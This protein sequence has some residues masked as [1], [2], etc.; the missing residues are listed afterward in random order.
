MDILTFVAEI[1]KALAWPLATIVIVT[2]FRRPLTQLLPLLRRVKYGDLEAEF[3][4]KI[5]EAKSE[6]A[7]VLPEVT[8]K[9][10]APSADETRL[11]QLSEISPRAAV[12]EAF[13]G[14][15]LAAISAARK[16]GMPKAFPRTLTYRALTFLEESGKVDH[17]LVTLL[18]DLRGL[19]NQAAHAPEF[20]LTTD[21]ALQ[22][23]QIAEAVIGRLN[24]ISAG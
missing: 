5:E 16:L 24:Q 4:R 14:V 13:T 7:A 1:V 18:R 11:I 2:I 6:A 22:Y 17:Q 3:E 21:A 23:V 12:L 8:R 15:E 19:R 10:L 20:G 9:A